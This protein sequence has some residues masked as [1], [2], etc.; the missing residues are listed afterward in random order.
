MTSAAAHAKSAKAMSEVLSQD[1][2]V[3]AG[4]STHAEE[5]GRE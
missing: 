1:Q 5:N 3:S 2:M 4:R